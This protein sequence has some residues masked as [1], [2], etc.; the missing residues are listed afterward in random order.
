MDRGDWRTTVHYGVTK[1]W[2]HLST[3]TNTEETQYVNLIYITS[4]L[5]FLGA[6][7]K[8]GEKNLG[9]VVYVSAFPSNHICSHSWTSLTV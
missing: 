1:S 4:D 9:G 7:V 5:Y 3:H 6:E 8:G 2:T